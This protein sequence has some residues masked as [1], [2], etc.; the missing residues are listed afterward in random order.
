MGKARTI[1]TDTR[2][3]EKAGD[4]TAFFSKM[5][6]GYKV[7][8]IVSD[9]DALDLKALLKRH[10]EYTDKVGVG[11]DHFEVAVPPEEYKGQCF[12]IIR[13]DGS[14]EAFSFKH[15]LEKKVGD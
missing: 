2:L 10:D 7:G 3:F 8:Q 9:T 5:L 4:A 11:I 1:K 12:W 14:R 15:C 6:G 13:T